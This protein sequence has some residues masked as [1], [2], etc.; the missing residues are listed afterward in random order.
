[1]AE[2]ALAQPV[3]VGQGLALRGHGPAERLEDG[4]GQVF[5]T[6]AA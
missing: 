3:Q 2:R 1:M 4:S 5:A 6:A